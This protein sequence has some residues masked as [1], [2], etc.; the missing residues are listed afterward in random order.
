MGDKSPKAKEQA[1]KKKEL[2]EK[3]SVASAKDKQSKLS[4]VVAAAG[5]GKK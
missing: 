2:L 4:S 5:K 1:K 3:Q